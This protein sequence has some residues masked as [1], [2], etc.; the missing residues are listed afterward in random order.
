M[1]SDDEQARPILH[2]QDDN[3]LDLEPTGCIGRSACCNP[4]SSVHRFLALIF[5]CL[6]GFGTCTYNNYYRVGWTMLLF[7]LQNRFS[8]NDILLYLLRI[9]SLIIIIHARKKNTNSQ[10]ICCYMFYRFSRTLITN[11]CEW[12]R[13]ALFSICIQRLWHQKPARHMC[14][15]LSCM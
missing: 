15:L 8:I 9:R 5:M 2:D 4:T 11:K 10:F 13:A 14:A 1:A 3:E 7:C 12:L 6:L